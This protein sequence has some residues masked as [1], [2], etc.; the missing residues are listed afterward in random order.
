MSSGSLA[1]KVALITGGTKGVGKATAIRLA[2]DG[3]KVV[4]TYASDS[5][6]AMEVVEQIGKDHCLAIQAD[7]GNLTAVEGVVDA[8]IKSFGKIDILLP[9]AAVSYNLDLASATEDAFDSAFNVN[10]KG[11]LF[12]CQV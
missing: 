8:T 10:V 4:I 5:S 3:A 9:N 12:L 6:A 7:A 11:P 2:K 1:G